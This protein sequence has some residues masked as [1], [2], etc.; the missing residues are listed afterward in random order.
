M[1][2]TVSKNSS[3]HSASGWHQLAKGDTL[4]TNSTGQAELN[5]SACWPGHIYIFKDSGSAFHVEQCNKGV[6]SSGGSCTSFGT[7]YVGGCSA[8]F[9]VTWT[10]SAKI[11]KRGTSYSI[12]YL[13]EIRN[14]TLV[15]VLDGVVEVTPIVSFDPTE[16]GDTAELTSGLF[17]FTMPD[18][19]L[20]EVAGL[21]PRAVL[22]LEE[23]PA[24]AGELGIVDWMVDVRNR[25]SEDGVLPENWP[26]DLGG[27]EGE[28]TEPVQVTGN[29]GFVV[30]MDGGSLQDPA[31]QEGILRSVDWSVVQQ[32]VAPEGS[33][34]NALFRDELIIIAEELGYDPEL[35]SASFD[36]AGYERENP[37][38]VLYPAEDENLAKAAQLVVD[39]LREFGINAEVEPV[40]GVELNSL[41]SARI[42]AGIQV[43]S[44]TR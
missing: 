28:P 9:D 15:V 43:I 17:Y 13:P 41:I 10:G 32:S 26:P 35:A 29:G 11:T 3:P 44:L 38:S 30:T 34:A 16:L 21:P 2:S 12:T 27:P 6:F 31:V 24:V 37:V 5:F 20:A 4:T 39:Y 7:W 33:T 23:L 40:A 25:G 42:A 36:A 14:I 1:S 18:A 8:E 22:P 19:E